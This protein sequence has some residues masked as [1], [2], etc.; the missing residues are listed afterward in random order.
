MCARDRTV[1]TLAW[2]ALAHLVADFVIQTNWIA[3]NKATGGRNGWAAL[4]V[5]GFHVGLCLL[6]AV[7]AYGV[8]GLAYVLLVALTHMAVDRW[9]VRATRRAEKQALEA[10]RRR[11]AGKP[12]T[13]PSG[14]GVAWTPWPG[15]LFAADQALHL[16]IAVV[17]WLVLLQSQ[18]LMGGWSTSSTGSSGRGT[19]RPSMLSS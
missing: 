7:I 14:L 1:L 9:K 2:L 12:D 6:P 8:S 19:A 3:I 17:G 13:T 10:A 15:M 4:S 16:T 11:H 18:A 5:H